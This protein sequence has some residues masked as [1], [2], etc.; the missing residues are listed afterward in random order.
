MFDVHSKPMNAVNRPGAFAS[1]AASIVSRQAVRYAGVP[2]KKKI[3]LGN[4][5]CEKA[6][7]IS[8]AASAPLPLW[9]MSYQRRPVGFASSLGSPAKSCGKKPM[10]S[11]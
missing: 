3:S 1:S 6:T 4:V 5:P 10:L 2:G 9:T 11:E 8:I 7:M